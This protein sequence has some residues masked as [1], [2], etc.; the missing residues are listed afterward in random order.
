VRVA[1]YDHGGKGARIADALHAAGHT[2]VDDHGDVA[3]VDHDDTW[4]DV[5]RR[6]IDEH[7]RVVIYPHAGIPVL[8]WD[9]YPV[10]P[11]VRL[12]LCHGPGHAELAGLYA[13][14]V[15]HISVG[16]CYSDLAE[17][18]TVASVRRVLFAPLHPGNDGRYAHGQQEA[19]DATLQLLADAGLDVTVRD[20]R[21]LAHDDIDTHDLVVA[22][23]TPLALA[24][25]RG[26]PT[27]SFADDLRHDCSPFPPPVPPRHWDRLLPWMRYPFD[28]A[29]GPLVELAAAV[30]AQ[31]ASVAEWRR[32]FVGGPFDAR[33]AV[34]LIEAVAG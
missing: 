27:L 6:L 16:W 18:R 24:V 1:F 29:D 14:P 21:G 5:H 3:L 25:A 8:T 10:H 33:L 2:I 15:P 22:A 26:A 4:V 12:A 13:C 30:C 9:A 17:P 19:N 28:V 34:A 31:P 32:R 23:S 20:G 7:Q 11:H